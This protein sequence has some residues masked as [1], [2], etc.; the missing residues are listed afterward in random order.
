M[1]ETQVVTPQTSTP[2]LGS[3]LASATELPSIM[4][5]DIAL[6]QM[7]TDLLSYW[8]YI[9]PDEALRI[10]LKHGANRPVRPGVVRALIRTLTANRWRLTHQGLGFDRTPELR[11]GQHRLLAICESG[12][13]AVMMITLGLSEEAIHA[14]DINA[15]R[16]IA[17][18]L[19]VSKTAVA[20]A[21][22]L[23]TTGRASHPNLT[24]DEIA[25]I[26]DEYSEAIEIAQRAVP[27]GT[28]GLTGAVLAQI[29]A[30][31]A[32]G[33]QEERLIEFGRVLQ[34]GVHEEPDDI[35]AALLRRFL[36]S[37]PTVSKTH[38]VELRKIQR[39]IHAFC[40]RE[41]ISKLIASEKWIYEIPPRPALTEASKGMRSKL[42]VLE[43]LKN[44]GVI[45]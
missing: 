20:I 28:R 31:Y 35:S 2:R 11:D 23:A 43:H 26:L 4:V 42:T 33:E 45:R 5:G 6:Q 29:A 1:I 41:R 16:N 44:L 40:H 37:S 38:A 25:D 9:G 24:V 18:I 8:V 14:L 19:G 15:K 39:A 10:L 34:R 21:N 32:K 7:K 12:I 22:A 17:D 30:A 36:D 13:G 27:C 3:K